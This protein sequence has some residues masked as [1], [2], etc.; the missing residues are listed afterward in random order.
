LDVLDAER[1]GRGGSRLLEQS[2]FTQGRK[3]WVTPLPNVAEHEEGAKIAQQFL[4]YFTEP[5]SKSSKCV[6]RKVNKFPRCK[7]D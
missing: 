3:K 1:L 6:T 7:D 4:V 2:S 5:R